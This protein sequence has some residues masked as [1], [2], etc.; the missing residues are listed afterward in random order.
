MGAPLSGRPSIVAANES[1]LRSL[2]TKSVSGSP[3]RR[4][5]IAP[6]SAPPAPRTAMTRRSLPIR[7]L[8]LD[9]GGEP[10]PFSTLARALY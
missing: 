5:E 9:S 8:P 4:P 7:S 6:P 2:S 1:A 3:A 10:T